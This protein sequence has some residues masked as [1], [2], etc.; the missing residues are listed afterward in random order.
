MNLFILDADPRLS[1]MY[2]VDK[3]VVKMPTETAQMLSFAY[4]HAE[5]WSNPIPDFIMAYSKTH[6]KHPCSVWMQHSIDNFLY[7]AALGL[8]LYAEYQHRYG[9]DKHVRAKMIF[10]Y[11]INNPPSLPIRG[12]TPFATAM[13][14]V[15]IQSDPIESYRNYYSYGKMHLH[16]WTKRDKPHWIN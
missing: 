1:A 5:Y 16:K 9:K 6:D 13:D 3:H 7:A 10:D 15:Y 4:H 2:H 12:L 11:A 14:E 8:E